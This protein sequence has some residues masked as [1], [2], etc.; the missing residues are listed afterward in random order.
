MPWEGKSALLVSTKRCLDGKGS[1]GKLLRALRLN[2]VG[3]ECPEQEAGS[4]RSHF[5]CLGADPL[6]SFY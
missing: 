4:V 2:E 1:W 5:T 6:L 3:G